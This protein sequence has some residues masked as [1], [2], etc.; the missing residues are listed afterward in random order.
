M[1]TKKLLIRIKNKNRKLT[2]LAPVKDSLHASLLTDRIDKL[3]YLKVSERTFY[4]KCNYVYIKCYCITG[5]FTYQK[6]E[7][8]LENMSDLIIINHESIPHNTAGE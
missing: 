4:P 1:R 2:I 8:D 6:L 7:N 3:Y 5:E